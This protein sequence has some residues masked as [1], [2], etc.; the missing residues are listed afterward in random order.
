M[1]PLCCLWTTYVI[2]ITI[3]YI[4]EQ[5]KLEPNPTTHLNLF[6][7]QCLI[8]HTCCVFANEYIPHSGLILRREIFMDETIENF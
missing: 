7:D 1:A 2:F 6:L 8:L 3:M 4:K 5:S